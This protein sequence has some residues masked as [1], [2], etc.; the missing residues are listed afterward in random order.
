VRYAI[1]RDALGRTRSA[2]VHGQSAQGTFAVVLEGDGEGG[3][4]VDG[5]PAPHLDGAL[6]VDLESSS[7]TNAFP[8]GRLDLR[9][10]E[11]A[12][13]PAAW[14]RQL[15]GAVERL[16]QRYERLAGAGERY[17][18][19]SLADGFRSELAY[20]ASG[21]VLDYPGIATRAG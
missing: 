12:D 19:V 1:D 4:H 18:Y 9:P 2:V 20:D 3:W 11:R 13:A 8:V 14:V 17:A 15:D 21:L 5:A 10:G 7:M 16:E 6:D